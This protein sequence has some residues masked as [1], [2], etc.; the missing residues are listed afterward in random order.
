MEHIGR[1]LYIH[2]FLSRFAFYGG[3][4]DSRT[5]SLK[6]REILSESK[7]IEGAQSGLGKSVGGL[8]WQVTGI[9]GRGLSAQKEVP[10]GGGSSEKQC[11]TRARGVGPTETKKTAGLR[12][13]CPKAVMWLV[14]GSAIQGKTGFM[15]YR[16]VQ[17][18]PL[19]VPSQR[20]RS[21]RGGIGDR[22]QAKGQGALL[23][24][25]RPTRPHGP[26]AF[27]IL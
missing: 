12:P 9:R 6:E 20:W 1:E 10:A 2:N 4:D 26:G 7:G 22:H 19:R 15:Q 24:A 18:G 23:G 25:V 17:T 3:A 11:E 8:A 5:A 21:S 27:A 16:P 14:A 13:T